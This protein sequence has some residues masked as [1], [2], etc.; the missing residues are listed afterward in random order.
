MQKLVISA[1]TLLIIDILFISLVL[2]KSFNKQILNVQGSPLVLNIHGALVSYFFLILGLYYFIIQENRPIHDSF[3]L[4]LIIYGIYDATN[5]ATITNWDL[6]TSIID[7]LWGGTLYGLTTFL[8]YR[9][10]D[11]IN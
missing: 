11:A 5:Y 8:T 10:V 1:I 7:T 6:K 2:V 9:I 3:L 4:G